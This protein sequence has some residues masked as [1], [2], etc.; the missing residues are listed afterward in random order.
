VNSRKGKHYGLVINGK[1]E[2]LKD[3]NENVFVKQ[4]AIKIAQQNHNTDQVYTHNSFME[5]KEGKIE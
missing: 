5:K 1:F 3:G 2:E 4:Q